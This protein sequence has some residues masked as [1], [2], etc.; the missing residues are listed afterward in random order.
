[1]QKLNKTEAG[2]PC[3][4][5]LALCY[6]IEKNNDSALYYYQKCVKLGEEIEDETQLQYAW[7]GLGGIYLNMGKAAEGESYLL[8]GLA[9][10]EKFHNLEIIRDASISLSAFYQEKGNYQKAFTYIQ[11]GDAARDS[12]INEDKIKEIA[13]L[14]AKMEMREME[15]KNQHLQ[16][17]NE[18]QKLRLF[19]KNLIIYAVIGTMLSLLIFGIL[20]FRNNR[21]KTRQQ[22]LELEQ[23]QLRA[24]M[25]P[26]FI[27]NCLN[28]IQH[29]MVYNDIQNA[30]KYLT[31][32]ASLMR[33]T[34]DI[35]GNNNITLMQE[36]DY[37]ENYLLL[38]QMRF[39]NHFSYEISIDKNIDGHQVE[40]PPMIIQPFVENAIRHGFQ[41]LENEQQGKLLISF[42]KNEKGII[43][44]ID[45]N[46]IGRKKAA[47]MKSNNA[48]KHQSFGIS[49]T[50]QRID[51]MNKLKHAG[52]DLTII[53][54][55]SADKQ[56]LGTQV[57]F[58]IPKDE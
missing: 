33:K 54:K 37:L 46:G 2:Y 13:Q 16:E 8:K 28:S 43:C 24:Q 53:D 56:A 19:R 52:Y 26:H 22:H 32:F 55:E 42:Q 38:E 4:F 15:M 11:K 10:A 7:T 41:Y 12:L 3:L 29:Y 44:T 57:I 39:D 45:D 30:N 58:K 49:L 36:K 48:K 20:L 40:I 34:L 50:K 1:M 9:L 35:V 23:K 21:M 27:F 5:N 14:S 47:E 31:E 6:E 17:E 51:L 18:L 25:N